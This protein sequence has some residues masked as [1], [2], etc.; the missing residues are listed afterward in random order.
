MGEPGAVVKV[1]PIDSELKERLAR[2]KAAIDPSVKAAFVIS[3][4]GGH[5]DVAAL[6]VQLEIG[7]NDVGKDDL[8]EC[9]AMLYSQAHAL[10]AIFVDAARQVKTQE[11]FSNSES[12]MR[13]GLKAQNQCRITLETLA[14]IKN[15]PAVFARQAN[16]AQGPQQVNNN[17]MMPGGRASRARGKQKYAKRTIGRETA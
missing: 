5:P 6:A 1:K 3:E 12:F 2:A 11:W 9:E 14:Q 17:G 16:I 13:M 10:Q 4:F 8:R 7:M 15:P